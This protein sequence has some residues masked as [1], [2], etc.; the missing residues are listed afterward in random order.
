MKARV[1]HSIATLAADLADCDRFMAG[2]Y[3]KQEAQGMRR[4]SVLPFPARRPV[5]A[6]PARRA[7]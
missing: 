4:A 6:V 5:P 1:R 2:W 7:A 3:A